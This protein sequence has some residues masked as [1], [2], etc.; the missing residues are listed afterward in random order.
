MQSI[1]LDGKQIKYNIKHKNIDEIQLEL[2]YDKLTVISPRNINKSAI[3]EHIDKH[4]KW[5]SSHIGEKGKFIYGRRILHLGIKKLLE[6]NIN[7][8]NVNSLELIEGIFYLNIDTEKNT[9][10]KQI[11]NK[12]FNEE[13]K[14]QVMGRINNFKKQVGVS[15]K[16]VIID[17]LF[18]RWGSCS[19]FGNMKFHFKCSMLPSEILDYVVMH[20]LCH[21]LYFNHSEEYWLVVEKFMP[22]YKHKKQ[23][24]DENGIKILYS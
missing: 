24:L 12:W 3:T 6:I 2:Q 1:I 15:P 23:W 16:K 14:N 5:I 9:L 13:S 20:E 11:I 8:D 19:N 10:I 22:D 21:L 17:N 18:L 4:K 7:R